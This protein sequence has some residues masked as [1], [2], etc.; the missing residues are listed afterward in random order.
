MLIG[1]TRP[2]VTLL[3]KPSVPAVEELAKKL[4]WPGQLQDWLQSSELLTELKARV[5]EL[6]AKLPSQDR[7]KETEVL[8]DEFTMDNG[9]LTPTLKVRRREVE[10]RFKAKI[11]AMYERLEKLRKG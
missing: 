5:D 10:K 6:T 2:F 8:E 11:D 1:D 3:V 4:Q 9:L 7:P